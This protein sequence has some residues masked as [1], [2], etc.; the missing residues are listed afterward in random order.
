MHADLL[1]R[2]I[3]VMSKGPFTTDM[4]AREL[5]ISIE[6]ADAL[7]GALLAHG[8]LRQVEE[9]TCK[10]CPL[11]GRCPASLLRGVK[12]YELTGKAARGRSLF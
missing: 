8:Y 6:E 5:S 2:A 3:E 4:L 7:I 11:S 1:R 12:L 10:K 9:S